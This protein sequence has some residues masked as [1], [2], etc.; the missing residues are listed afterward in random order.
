[1]ASVQAKEAA[2][3]LLMKKAE[4]KFGKVSADME[5]VGNDLSAAEKEVTVAV[6]EAEKAEQDLA[7]QQSDETAALMQLASLIQEEHQVL[8]DHLHKQ[9]AEDAA[10]LRN[11][12]VALNEAAAKGDHE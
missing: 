10:R 1:M 6:E 5:K 2:S 7:G 4:D 11:H 3:Q 9:H 8:H 12:D